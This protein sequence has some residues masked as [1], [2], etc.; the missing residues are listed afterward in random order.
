MGNITTNTKKGLTLPTLAWVSAFAVILMSSTCN[1]ATL[2]EANR[3]FKMGYYDAS[4]QTA[5]KV[6]SSTKVKEDK[7]KAYLLAGES[8]R[9][10][11]SYEQAIKNYDK[12]LAKDA[13]NTRALLMKGIMLQK[14]EK[15]RE[16]M[17][18]FDAYLQEV[19]G[20]S[21]AIRKKKGC[22]LALAWKEG[23]CAKFKVAPFQRANSKQHDF[24]PMMASKK[25]DILIFA[26]DREEGTSKKIYDGTGNPWTDLWYVK[27]TGKGT[28]EKWDKAV[29]MKGSSSK[30]N[31]GGL[32]F[33]S[34][35]NTMYLTQCGGLNGKTQSCLIYEYKK[36]GEDWKMNEMLEF[37]KNDTAHFYGHPT[38]SADGK[39][40]Y[41]A[42]NREGGYGGSDI[43]VVNISGRSNSWGE[44]INLGP[45]IN[46]SSNEYWPYINPHDNK[47]YFSSDGWPGMGGLDMF[48]ATPTDDIL[49]WK[50]VE[51]LLPPF[52]SSADDF[53]VTFY[54]NDPSHGFFTSNRGD[55]KNND[56]IFEF[57]RIPL[58][59]T[60][61]GT[62]TDCDT[63]KPLE[64]ATVIITND[65]D[66]SKIVMKT[67]ALGK[68]FVK[69]KEK[70]N[71]EVSAKY[72]EKYYL[73]KE[74]PKRVSTLKVK[75]DTGYIRDFCLEN[76]LTKL[77]VLPIFYDLDKDFIRPDAAKILDN[78]A[79]DVLFKYPFIKAE[80]GSHT[81]CRAPYEY[82][83][84][85]SARRAKNAR[86]YLIK[87]LKIDS[88][89]I[90]ARGYGET[91]LINDCKCEG[92]DIE[93][94]TQYYDY[95]D[96][97]G[98]QV[99]TRKAM[100]L[101]DEAGNVIKSWYEDYKPGEI[102]TINGKRVVPCDEQQHQQNRRTTVRLSYGN[103]MSR[104]TVNQDKD[105]N[106][107]NQNTQGKNKPGTTT[108]NNTTVAAGA[109]D[110]TK[111]STAIKVRAYVREKD[112]M[113]AAMVNNQES[114]EFVFDITEKQNAIPTEL[115]AQWLQSK[116][117]NKGM[118]LDGDKIKVGKV[119]LPSNKLE[120]KDLEIGSYKFTAPVTLTITDKV[121]KPTLG[122]P[123]IGKEFKT[124]KKV[125]DYFYLIPKKL[126]KKPK[127][128]KTE[129]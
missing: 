58:V 125:G 95:V 62:V 85:L 20:D 91:Q 25:D 67:D 24:A 73:E 21:T 19:P 128:V 26:S 3:Q 120:I 86:E 107:R 119:S 72:P 116:L 129:E 6:A 68:Y 15:Y 82:N 33:N 113:V 87:T 53:G 17:T 14:L 48:M 40:L 101:K 126:P 60:L 106:N 90:T 88:N 43:W 92:T 109:Y 50:E 65:A 121:E 69:I 49:V 36:E 96:S 9:M 54:T 108:G 57:N 112:T 77:I 30:Y 5:E 74:E 114:I 84:D 2:D 79:K 18:I 102:Q 66:T 42:S 81:D 80:L 124:T 56:N 118:F 23:K 110:I 70:V 44:P 7:L 100:V 28:K 105:R 37:C 38:L 1:K 8:H 104:V 35:F 115:A 27:K 99:K 59:I 46:T 47:L 89:R 16:A 63:R 41:F 32:A 29:F 71:Y 122:K 45:T 78:F 94:F 31:E 10:K 97:N 12:V 75:C 98:N 39:R 34:K 123:A 4:A 83:V 11:S 117:I 64:G 93:G 51:N 55:R 111:D 52:N 127:K 13:K 22:E 61:E 103:E 76:P